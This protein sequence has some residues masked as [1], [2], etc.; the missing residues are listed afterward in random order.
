MRSPLAAGARFVLLTSAV[1]VINLTLDEIRLPFNWR[2]GP[3]SR[4]IG[5]ASYATQAHAFAGRGLRPLAPVH[6]HGRR[7]GGDLEISWIRR[8]RTGGD[9]WDAAE[10]PLGEDSE[11]YEVDVLDGGSIVRTLTAT[12]ATVSYSASQQIEDFGAVQGAVSVKVYQLGTVY[13]R[14][15]AAA[16]T[17]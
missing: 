12:A 2:F 14:G 11:R 10:V 4:D 7:T 17:V 6:V 13:G 1:A 15:G 8:T 3:A 9:S 16:A 5:D